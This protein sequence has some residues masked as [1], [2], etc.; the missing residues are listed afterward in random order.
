MKRFFRCCFKGDNGERVKYSVRSLPCDNHLSDTRYNT[1]DEFLLRGVFT[2]KV[3]RVYDGDTFWAAILPKDGGKPMRIIC[4]LLNI[5]TR[6]MP[7]S[8]S[9]AMT[10]YHRRAF[11]ARDRLIQLV[12]DVEIPYKETYTD[13][14]GTP[15][16]S[17]SDAEMQKLV[18]QNTA[19]LHDALTLENGT[20]KYGRYLV[21]LLSLRD[22]EDVSTIMLREEHGEDKKKPT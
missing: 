18:D 7:V 10:D 2:C 21:T 13:T 20:D 16:P 4:R 9:Q 1:T 3:I 8:H 11:A 22:K 14:S 12:T 6:E 5:D 15:L 17:Y 19:V